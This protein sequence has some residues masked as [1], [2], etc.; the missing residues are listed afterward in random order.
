MPNK[1]KTPMSA[2]APKRP[3]LH[4]DAGDGAT[5][6]EQPRSHPVYGQKNA[7]PGLDDAGD[8]LFYG[9]ADDGLEYLRMVR[10]E[11]NALP[12][13][14][15]AESSQTVTATPNSNA[16]VNSSERDRQK[17]SFKAGFYMDEA[18]VAPANSDEKSLA[19]LE[20]GYPEAQYS[21]YNLL[22]HRF[23]LLRSTLRCTP[24]AT[25]IAGLD[26]SHPISLP[27]NHAPA[28]K[29]WR[30]LTLAVDP[31]MVQLACMDSESVLSVLQVIAR[32]LSDNVRSGDTAGIRRL[33]AWVWG[34]LGKCREVGELSTEEVGEIRDLGKRAAKI[35]EKVREAEEAGEEAEEEEEEAYEEDSPTEEYDQDGKEEPATPS[36][37]HKAEE[38]D[39]HDVEMP[40]DADQPDELAAAKARLQARLQDSE[41]AVPEDTSNSETRVKQIRAMLDMIITVVGEFFGQ[42]DLL[43]AREV[44]TGAQTPP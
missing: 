10:S 31:Q 26:D 15:I 18:Y 42:R 12:S 35:L 11:A 34:L 17:L 30:R 39:T 27:R 2:P 23:L 6:H 7:F 44:W 19:S 1:R 24:P 43:E 9:P 21:Y 32:G 22:R 25:A 29:E 5:P 4:E 14:F 16:P 38:S 37:E 20:K 33:G 13:L 28:R 3:R 41:D 40:S 8:E 36:T